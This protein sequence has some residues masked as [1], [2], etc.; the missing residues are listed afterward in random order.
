ME[1]NNVLLLTAHM[2]KIS[3]NLDFFG[4][5]PMILKYWKKRL[6]AA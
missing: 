4:R 6:T 5:T 3:R 2:N 1:R